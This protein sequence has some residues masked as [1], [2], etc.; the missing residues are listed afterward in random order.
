MK[1]NIRAIRNMQG[2]T[3]EQLAEK[4]GISRSYLTELELG[5]KVINANR[6]E[7]I[8]K[9][10]GVKIADLFP[11]P[12]VTV[13]ATGVVGPDAI[14]I[15]PEIDK[16]Y[17]CPS[18]LNPEGLHAVVVGDTGLPPYLAA[19]DVVFYRAAGVDQSLERMAVVAESKTGAIRLCSARRGT[20]PGRYHLDLPTGKAEWDR[21][22]DWIAP[23]ELLL[24]AHLAVEART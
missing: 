17:V 8:A 23:V 18:M 21:E 11:D 7:Q 9:A 20:S 6:L 22:I 19:G 12:S 5:A 14:V 15:G 24:P 1:L 2:L 16:R 13:A 3:I 4:A 10:L